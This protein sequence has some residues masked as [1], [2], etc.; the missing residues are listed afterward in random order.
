MCLAV[1][2]RIALIHRSDSESD[3]RT[4]ATVD[5]QGS[6]VQIS[7]EL[8]PDARV[9]D[10]V[11]VHAGFAL[12]VLDE[13]EARELWEYLQEADVV[14]EIPVFAENPVREESER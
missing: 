8:T 10:W 6:R 2:G 12:Q 3:A 5:F 9:E 14:R 1:P 4:T 13:G 11:L 7:L